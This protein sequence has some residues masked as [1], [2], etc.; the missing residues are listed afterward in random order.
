MQ[1]FVEAL[2][3]ETLYATTTSS[4]LQLDS[5]IEYSVVNVMSVE[6]NIKIERYELFYS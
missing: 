5:L 1:L 6:I 2:I 3:E 4:P